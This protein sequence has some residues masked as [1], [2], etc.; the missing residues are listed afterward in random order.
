MVNN[1]IKRC[2]ER[3]QRPNNNFHAQV[4]IVSV[5]R[6]RDFY[7][8]GSDRLSA[9]VT[10]RIYVH[11]DDLDDLVANYAFDLTVATSRTVLRQILFAHY[12]LIRIFA[13]EVLETLIV[14]A[15]AETWL[16]NL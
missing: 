16:A 10:T 4:R 3:E 8:V 11:T 2:R 7:N 13:G 12:V 6:F 15:L 9:T 1:H 14:S 5:V